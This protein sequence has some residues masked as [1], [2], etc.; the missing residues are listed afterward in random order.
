M[1]SVEDRDARPDQELNLRPFNL[2]DGMQITKW[3][4]Q[5]TNDNL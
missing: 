3:S 4:D 1:N 5:P 2:E